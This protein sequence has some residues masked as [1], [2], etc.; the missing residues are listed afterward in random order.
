MA[1]AT[2][3]WFPLF[4][5]TFLATT[6]QSLTAQTYF[7]VCLLISP[8]HTELIEFMRKQTFSPAISS[9]TV[10]WAIILKQRINEAKC[11]LCNSQFL[12]IKNILCVCCPHVVERTPKKKKNKNETK[13]DKD[14]IANRLSWFGYEGEKSN[15]TR[16]DVHQQLPIKLAKSIKLPN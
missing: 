8:S 14:L 5:L 10:K 1:P 9:V 6:T 11:C 7:G 4:S 16:H 3:K 12:L 15:V 2:T 13:A